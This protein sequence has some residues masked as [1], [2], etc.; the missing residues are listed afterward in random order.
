MTIQIDVQ[1][2]QGEFALNVQL[3]CS[4]QG[5]SALFGPSG[6]GKS[7]MLRCIAGIQA[8]AVGQIT[9]PWGEWQN[10]R[11]K[12][13]AWRRDVGMVFQHGALFPHLNVEENLLYS[14]KRAC[15]I[16]AQRRH[17][18]L[19]AMSRLCGIEALFKHY[20]QQLSGGQQQRVAI[21][22]A[23]LSKP[24]L[25]LLDEPLASLDTKTRSEF[26]QLLREV[27]Q[28]TKLPMLY[29]SHQLEEIAQLADEIHIM[30]SGSLVQSGKVGEV[31][32]GAIGT[33]L[34][35]GLTVLEL[36]PPSTASVHAQYPLSAGGQILELTQ[37]SPLQ[38]ALVY[39]DDVSL[40]MA[41]LERSSIRNQ[42]RAKVVKFEPHPRKQSSQLVT[43][44]VDGQALLACVSQHALEELQ[45]RPG[46]T[47]IALIKAVAL[48]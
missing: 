34:S 39:A 14:V 47:V 41:P 16:Q 35:G 33:E 10:G 30:Q 17:A 29:V 13:A 8:H 22:R 11:S 20:P 43:L 7:T 19:A 3:S 24:K 42:L 6:C 21:A 1:A 5:I 25:L 2:R 28:R 38:R 46:Q 15:G 32:H 18:E 37:P 4:S 48:H 40:S 44:T 9:T 31:L 12:R 26:V 27:H 36:G 23:L 45:I